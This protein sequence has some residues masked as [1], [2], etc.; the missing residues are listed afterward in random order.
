MDLKIENRTSQPLEE[1]QALIKE[2][3]PHAKKQLGF[4]KPVSVNFLSDPANSANPLG[5]TAHYDPNNYSI[6]LYID[7]RH[8]KDIL[9]SFSHELVHHRQNCQGKFDNAVAVEGYA[10]QDDHLREMEKEAYLE[11][12]MLLRDWEDSKKQETKER[13]P[14]N[15]QKLRELTRK[16]IEELNTRGVAVTGKIAETESPEEKDK[17]KEKP[18]EEYK[19]SLPDTPPPGYYMDNP[20]SRYEEGITKEEVV[21]EKKK[22]GKKGEYDDNDGEDERCDHVPCKDRTN[23]EMELDEAGCGSHKRD[24]K[25]EEET[26]AEREEREKAEQWKHDRGDYPPMPPGYE[27][28]LPKNL[29]EETKQKPTPIHESVAKKKGEV[30]FDRLMNKWCK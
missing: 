15:E 10:Q 7:K 4:N 28:N 8:P 16:V 9:R 23:E 21:E 20:G 11:G 30:L 1:I 25:L 3:Y 26:D 18:E 12:N 17:N 27:K 22:K 24:D 19:S 14:M 13:K 5:K 29:R 6:G 2:F